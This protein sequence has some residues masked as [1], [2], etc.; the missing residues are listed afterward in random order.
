MAEVVEDCLVCVIVWYEDFVPVRKGLWGAF[1]LLGGHLGVPSSADEDL[2][3]GDGTVEIQVGLY[4]LVH[5]L[6]YLGECLDRVPPQGLAAEGG[7][8]LP[9]ALHTV[10][11]G[12]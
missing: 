8:E 9:L 4:V 2:T 10:E 3:E 1:E 7:N 12:S 6:H 5:Y 11:V